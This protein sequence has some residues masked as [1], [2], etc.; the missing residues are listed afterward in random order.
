[1][2]VMM[3]LR[4][5]RMY[6]HDIIL[7]FIMDG[8]GRLSV[9]RNSVGAE[10]AVNNQRDHSVVQVTSGMVVDASKRRLEVLIQIVIGN[11]DRLGILSKPP[12]PGCD[13]GID[14]AGRGWYLKESYWH[15]GSNGRCYLMVTYPNQEPYYLDAGLATHWSFQ[16][17]HWRYLG[18][19]LPYERISAHEA[20][21]LQLP[22]LPQTK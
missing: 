15:T 3:I 11:L 6:D 22:A 14:G 7:S 20:A 16:N 13:G 8:M 5:L 21:R 4:S 1:M 19:D 18:S 10:C 17:G 2:N 9:S 12:P